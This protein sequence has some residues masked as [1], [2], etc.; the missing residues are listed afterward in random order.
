MPALRHATLALNLHASRADTGV[1]LPVFP[2]LSL[3]LPKSGIHAAFGLW[4]CFANPGDIIHAGILPARPRLALVRC[5]N[6][7]IG[8][9][10]HGGNGG[11]R[12]LLLQILC[13]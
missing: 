12:S 8:I 1:G 3:A 5:Q 13:P 9:F 6:N 7:R 2:L 11:T 4:V 10:Y